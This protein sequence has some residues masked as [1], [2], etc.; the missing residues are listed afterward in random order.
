MA[1]KNQLLSIQRMV[2]TDLESLQ[3][4]IFLVLLKVKPSETDI[5]IF[6]L[7]F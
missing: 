2:S 6:D 3:K 1:V 7:R 5:D 4:A